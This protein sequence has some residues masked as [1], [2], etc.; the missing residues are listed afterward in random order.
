MFKK[1]QPIWIQGKSCEMNI[2]AVF[3][4]EIKIV[5][6]MEVHIAGSAFYRIYVDG[7][8]VG[9]GPARTARGYLR[10]DIFPLDPYIKSNNGSCKILI[11]AMGYHCCSLSTVL[12]ASCI[13]A[14]IQKEE[15]VLAYTGQDFEAFL[16]EYKVQKTERYSVQRHFTEIYDYRKCHKLTDPA[17]RTGVDVLLDMPQILKRRAP[18]PLYRDIDLKSAYLCGTYVFDET[19]P[20]KERRYSWGDVPKNWGTFAWEDIP[21]HPYTWIQ[22]Q[23][24]TVLEKKSKLPLVLKKGEYA[25][26]DFER[27]EAGFLRASLKSI[28]ESDIVIAFSEFYQGKEFEFSNMNVHNVLEYL[29]TAGDNR[30]IQSFEPYTFRYVMVAV[31]EGCI[32]LDSLGVKT[33]I[34]D[35]SNVVWLK[36]QNDVQDAICRAAVRTFSH[37]AVDLYT[38][39]PSRERAGWLCDSYFTARTEY[40]LTGKTLVEDAFLENYRLFENS[41]EYPAG[42]LPDCYPSDVRMNAEFIPQWTMWYILE[43]EEYILKRCHQNMADDFRK[44]IFGLIDFYRQYENEDGL[45]ECLPSWNFVEWSK[46]NEWTKDVN[47]PTNFLYSQVLEAVY[48]IYGDETCHKRIQCNNSKKSQLDIN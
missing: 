13:I 33:Y 12:E 41:G 24:Q 47:Y 36:C 48:H 40:K 11:E 5:P 22:R 14:E 26:L 16:P 42:V 19:K 37:N 10:E 21:Y 38:D 44:S 17:Y 23:R 25:V 46:A 15:C 30:R 28:K 18:Y 4:T 31:K 27:I 2:Y 1:A 45:L 43:V 3:Q 34:Y 7:C 32:Q 35:I 9:F 6:E 29:L 8:F 20:Y 39:C